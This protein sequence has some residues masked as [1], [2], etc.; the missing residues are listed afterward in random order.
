M[1]R[2]KHLLAYGVLV[3]VQ[4]HATTG[5][6]K[7]V[8][9]QLNYAW[10]TKVTQS[11]NK[12]TF[13]VQRP[14]RITTEQAQAMLSTVCAVDPMKGVS[15][16]HITNRNGRGYVVENFDCGKIFNLPTKQ[17]TNELIRRMRIK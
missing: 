14:D 8:E 16:V 12:I 10:P 1:K 17:A 9:T 15:E 5:M 11:A 2:A 4:L 3:G 7:R 13:A 6:V